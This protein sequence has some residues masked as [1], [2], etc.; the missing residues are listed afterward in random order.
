MTR[1]SC[2]KTSCPPLRR[3][4]PSATAKPSA[5][6]REIADCSLSS[7]TNSKSSCSGQFQYCGHMCLIKQSVILSNYGLPSRNNQAS[8]LRRCPIK[9]LISPASELLEHTTQL[10]MSG[11]ELASIKMLAC[12]VPPLSVVFGSKVLEHSSDAVIRG[13]CAV[14]LCSP[15]T[16]LLI[17]VKLAATCGNFN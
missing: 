9:Y 2:A 7:N 6:S 5:T 12:T 16:F 11:L 13:P 17:L 10:M 4:R 1:A 15:L 8:P 14:L 3:L